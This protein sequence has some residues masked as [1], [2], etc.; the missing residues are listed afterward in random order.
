MRTAVF[1]ALLALPL[2]AAGPSEKPQVKFTTSLG[3]FTL[4]LEPKAAPKTVANFMKYVHKGFYKGTTF[5]RVI[6]TFMIQ[7][8]GFTADMKK[9]AGDP[10]IANEGKEAMAAGLHN[11]RGTIAM[12]RTNDPHSASSQFF[13]NVKD[14]SMSLDPKPDGWGYCVFGSDSLR[15]VQRGRE[16]RL[17]AQAGAVASARSSPRDTT[18]ASRRGTMAGT[19]CAGASTPR[20]D[21][22]YFL[23]TLGQDELKDVLFPIGHLAKPEVRAIAERH[24]LITSAK[25]ES[26]EICFVPN[27]DYAQFVEKVAGA[28]PKGDV[29]STDGEVLGTH[30]GIHRFTIG[31][32]RGLPVPAQGEPMYVQRIEA[33]TR[34]VVVGPADVIARQSFHLLRPRWVDGAAPVDRALQIRIRH[35]HLGTA[36]RVSIDGDGHVAVQ[37]ETPAKAVTPG[38]RN[39]VDFRNGAYL[40]WGQAYD[41]SSAAPVTSV[42]QWP[43]RVLLTGSAVML[44]WVAG[45]KQPAQ[46]P[47]AAPGA[48]PLRSFSASL[49]AAFRRRSAAEAP[50]NLRCFSTSF[51]LTN[52]AKCAIHQAVI[53]NTINT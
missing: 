43:D 2:L 13:I 48:S 5:H 40:S 26:I 3:S 28:Q 29:V 45:P 10:P 9:K 19:C 24:G 37:L 14:N 31:Q 21:R 11:T 30:D 16:V 51:A 42:R 25:P 12:A 4:Q 7:G 36:G 18:R 1:S 47:A 27:G 49:A 23:F 41:G 53:K 15:V 8:G 52:I 34:K 50:A 35:R 46:Q 22:S 32:R 20:R 33:E 17:P 44:R 6:P 39:D 38:R